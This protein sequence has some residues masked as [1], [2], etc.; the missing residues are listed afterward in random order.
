LRLHYCAKKLTEKTRQDVVPEFYIIIGNS[1]IVSYKGR[2]YDNEKGWK[3]LRLRG[4]IKLMRRKVK[5]ITLNEFKINN[6]KN[7]EDKIK[8]RK[9]LIYLNLKKI[10]EKNDKKRNC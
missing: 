1:S 9:R 10:E 8:K 2:P 4:K 6:M 3:N 5:S 7:V